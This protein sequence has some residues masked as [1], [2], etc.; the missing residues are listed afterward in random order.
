MC[1]GQEMSG[2]RRKFPSPQP[3]SIL[4]KYFP[5]T[6]LIAIV[7]VVVVVFV[8]V[9][10]IVVTFFFFFSFLIRLVM[11]IGLSPPTERKRERERERW[12]YLALEHFSL[13]KRMSAHQKFF[14]FLPTLTVLY[15]SRFSNG[16]KN[17]NE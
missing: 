8:S 2:E 11:I 16:H 13:H 10:V 17:K 6:G 3:C 9:F 15:T 1:N 14:F 12:Y 5:T 4:S 7:V